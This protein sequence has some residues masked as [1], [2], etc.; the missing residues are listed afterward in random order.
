MKIKTHFNAIIRLI[1]VNEAVSPFAT[2]LNR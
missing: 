2:Q 1:A